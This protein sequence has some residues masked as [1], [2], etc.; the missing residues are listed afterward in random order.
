MPHIKHHDKVL[1]SHS[2]KIQ[3]GLFILPEAICDNY[4]E[5][6]SSMRLGKKVQN[7]PEMRP[8]AMRLMSQELLEGAPDELLTAFRRR[9]E[10]HSICEA[11]PLDLVPSFEGCEC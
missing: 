1:L 6:A 5:T 8:Q 10:L 4:E 3:R 9:K 7:W 2:S 11:Q